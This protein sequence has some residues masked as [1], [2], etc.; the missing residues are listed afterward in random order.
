MKVLN[1]WISL[2][3]RNWADKCGQTW[4]GSPGFW[5]VSSDA[6]RSEEPSFSTLK[7]G[8]NRT[9]LKL[10]RL[11]F[12]LGEVSWPNFQK[13]HDVSSLPQKVTFHLK[14]LFISCQILR[15]K[16]IS[17]TPSQESSKQK[18]AF[19]SFT[20]YIFYFPSWTTG[21]SANLTINLTTTS[22]SN[23]QTVSPTVS[24]FNRS[25]GCSGAHVHLDPAADFADL[26]CR[27]HRRPHSLSERSKL[28][29]R[30]GGSGW[31]GRTQRWS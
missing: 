16:M 23:S 6:T 29:V 20:Y 14:L 8:T 11:A 5:M 4:G 18:A 12:V 28:F 27:S 7:E 1:S 22:F 30:V 21:I 19:T 2:R 26:A 3:H 9:P 17:E 31:K 15:L 24:S 13:W 10:W 25:G